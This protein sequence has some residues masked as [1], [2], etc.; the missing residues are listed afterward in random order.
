M[1]LITEH[2]FKRNPDKDKANLR[3]FNWYRGNTVTA[4]QDL[5]KAI[6][7]ALKQQKQGRKK[8]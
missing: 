5:A 6:R 2:P 4:D 8:S 3:E 1:T 7:L